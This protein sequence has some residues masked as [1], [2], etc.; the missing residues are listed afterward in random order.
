MHR[1]FP[2]STMAGT[3]AVTVTAVDG[4]KVSADDMSC[5]AFVAKVTEDDPSVDGGVVIG[6]LH[7]SQS[8]ACSVVSGGLQ[9]SH[10]SAICIQR[11]ECC[12]IDLLL[13]LFVVC[14]F[15]I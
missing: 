2:S 4:W 12:F 3:S 14:V 8:G 1:V 15:A 7:D 6:Y 13:L 11:G 10:N 9:T 5:A